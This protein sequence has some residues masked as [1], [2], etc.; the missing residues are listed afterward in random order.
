MM[1]VVDVLTGLQRR[2]SVILEVPLTSA[3]MTG[4]VT[5]VQIRKSLGGRGNAGEGPAE[6]CDRGNILAADCRMRVPE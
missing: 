2:A 4:V 3:M 1:M 5:F 6:C